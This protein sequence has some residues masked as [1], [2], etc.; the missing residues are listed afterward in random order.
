MDEF[1]GR[2]FK[3]SVKPKRETDGDFWSSSQLLSRVLPDVFSPVERTALPFF[4]ALAAP[5]LRALA[6]QLQPG[7]LSGDTE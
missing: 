5:P 6:E 7:S 2:M 1:F 3:R 4:L